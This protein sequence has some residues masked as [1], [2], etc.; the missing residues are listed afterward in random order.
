MLRCSLLWWCSDCIH[1]DAKYCI[2][3]PQGV[4]EARVQ[5]YSQQP[6]RGQYSVTQTNQSPLL[7]EVGAPVVGGQRLTHGWG[8][9][10]TRRP[11][12]C[13]R[14]LEAGTATAMWLDPGTN[15]PVISTEKISLNHRV[16]YFVNIRFFMI[17]NIDKVNEPDRLYPQWLRKFSFLFPWIFQ[18]KTAAVLDF[19]LFVYEKKSFIDVI[20]AEGTKD[21]LAILISKSD[22]LDLRMS[23]HVG[24]RLILSVSNLQRKQKV[25]RRKVE[26][27]LLRWPFFSS[28]MITFETWW[29]KKAVFTRSVLSSEV[30]S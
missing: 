7:F 25:E 28:W 8:G 15:N 5:V 13:S 24:P 17:P 20:Y 9:S 29:M 14:G 4:D 2:L 22:I 30:K 23:P 16:Y 6:I 27:I 18:N 12:E 1:L 10:Q 3:A 19:Y 21:V 26:N 11:R